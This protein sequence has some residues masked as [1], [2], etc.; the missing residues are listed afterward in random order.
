MQLM[1]FWAGSGALEAM[2]QHGAHVE[3]ARVLP[4][5]LLVRIYH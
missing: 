4:T 1:P 2:L 3:T 5:D